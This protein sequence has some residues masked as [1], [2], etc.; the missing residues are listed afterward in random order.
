MKAV[1]ANG[2]RFRIIGG[3]LAE[4][5]AFLIALGNLRGTPE[6]DRI[7]WEIVHNPDRLYTIRFYDDGEGS[8]ADPAFDEIVIDVQD[9]TDQQYKTKDG[10]WEYFSWEHIIAHEAGHL[11]DHIEGKKNEQKVVDQWENPATGKTGLPAR[12]RYGDTRKGPRRPRPGPNASPR[13]SEGDAVMP[14]SALVLAT[15]LC[16]GYGGFHARYRAFARESVRPIR[17]KDVRENSPDVTSLLYGKR[18]EILAILGRAKEK[19]RFG[20]ANVGLYL[21]LG[22]EEWAVD[23]SG[24]V[25]H[26]GRASRLSD[27]DFVRLRVLVLDVLPDIREERIVVDGLLTNPARRPPPDGGGRR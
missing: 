18:K 1:D 14:L 5:L 13:P 4:Q 2:E 22:K 23:A 6:G 26:A 15:L 9:L 19:G 11:I 3:S 17:L 25:L 27:D 16:D 7:I 21:R 24:S 10:K 20:E 8:E 12:G